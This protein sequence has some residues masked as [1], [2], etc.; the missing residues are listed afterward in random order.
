MAVFI[1]KSNLGSGPPRPDTFRLGRENFK[2]GTKFGVMADA[3]ARAREQ[4]KA[5]LDEKLEG[6]AEVQRWRTL[7]AEEKAR[8]A[9]TRMIPT[10]KA[11]EEQ[12]TGKECSHEDAR[13]LAESVA[14]KS[15]RIK[16]GE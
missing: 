9:I 15:D 2:G 4:K 7:T 13:K 12:R 6:N 8:D 1:K 14:Y 16:D 5:E 11:I 3:F 10:T